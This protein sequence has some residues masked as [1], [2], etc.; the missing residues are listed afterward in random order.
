MIFLCHAQQPPRSPA[1]MSHGCIQP[2]PLHARGDCPCSRAL[3]AMGWD[4]RVC[5][6]WMPCSRVCTPCAPPDDVLGAWLCSG[7]LSVLIPR[8]CQGYI[9]TAIRWWPLRKA[10]ILLCNRSPGAHAAAR[11]ERGAGRR[12]RGQKWVCPGRGNH[13]H[14]KQG[15]IPGSQ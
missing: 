12:G 14:P 2:L 10:N 9:A 4:C 6:P 13:I 8:L 7:C 3:Y 15:P 11:F 1:W 5:C